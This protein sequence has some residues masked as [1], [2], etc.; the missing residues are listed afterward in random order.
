M[1]QKRSA[2]VSLAILNTLVVV[3]LFL[4]LYVAYALA[5]SFCGF[6]GNS[7]C[8]TNAFPTW[9][10]LFYIGDSLFLF[11]A[12]FAGW[13]LAFKKESSPRWRLLLLLS[14]LAFL[15]VP[16][17][18]SVILPSQWSKWKT[19]P[20][21]EA[22][23]YFQVLHVRQ[24]N[25]K[26]A[27]KVQNNWIASIWD[28]T[29]LVDCIDDAGRPMASTVRTNLCSPIYADGQQIGVGNC[30][31]ISP[32]NSGDFIFQVPSGAAASTCDAKVIDWVH[33]TE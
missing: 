15:V 11:V 2:R 29:F 32:H 16:L 17:A 30:K 23:T 28:V 18:A 33:M 6:A 24:T 19:S 31:S 5:N 27:V 4:F 25:D 14:Y 3:F 22:T 26:L 8:G 12:L 21:S 1:L 20:E 13:R 10:I 9:V 7:P